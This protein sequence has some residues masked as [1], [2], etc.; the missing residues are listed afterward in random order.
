MVN[1][2]LAKEI[3]GMSPWFVDQETLPSLLAIL[4]NKMAL[5]LP[6]TKYNTPFIVSRSNTRL[7]ERDY[8]LNNNDFFSG[9]GIIR[10]DGPITLS[11]GQSSVG[12]EQLSQI[13]LKLS[14]DKRIKSFVILGNSGGGSSAAVEV[15]TDTIKEIDKIKPVFGLIKKGGIA[16]SACYGIMSAC[17]SLYA[18]SEMSFVGSAGTMV[19]FEGYAANSKAEDG[20]KRIR[21]YATKSIEKNIEFEEALNNDSYELITENIL[22]PVNERFLAAILENRPM[23]KGTNYDT[24]KVVF[25]K[26]AVGTFIDGL[27]TFAEV[28]LLAEQTPASSGNLINPNVMTTNELKQNHPDVYNEVLQLG[29]SSEKARVET[30]MAHLDADQKMVKEGVLSNAEL[31]GGKREEL[32]IKSYKSAHLKNLEDD[33]AEDANPPEA[34]ANA[35]TE[36]DQFNTR[37][38]NMLKPS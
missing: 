37:V 36:I 2:A 30:W 26:D 24:G 29:V 33:S 4:D 20:K 11:G 14:K 27:K 38:D 18:E 17:R 32:M 13:M 6:E 3:Y 12:I 8:Q 21:L 1:F 31:S 15:M 35:L 23:L 7:I 22:N 19:E 25:A 9:I 28:V 16:A 10:L 34:G 5:E